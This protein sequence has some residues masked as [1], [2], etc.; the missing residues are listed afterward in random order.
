MTAPRE[1]SE[2][3]RR[4]ARALAPTRV[5]L[6]A[7]E[8]THPDAPG[9]IRVVNDVA[10]REIEGKTYVALRFGARLASD[11]EGQPPRAELVLDN[12]GRVVTQWIEVARGGAGA[13]V[14]LIQVSVDPDDPAS[15]EVEWEQTLHVQSMQVDRAQVSA[16]IGVPSLRGRE[17]VI[18]R[19]DP[20]RSPGLF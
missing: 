18:A 9:P 16:R 7:L 13:V 3:W 6:I 20:S 19:H 11:T 15:A 4:A 17:A 12:V 1:A 14:R 2:R 5:L 8:I 10:D